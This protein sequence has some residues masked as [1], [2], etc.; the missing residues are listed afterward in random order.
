MCIRDSCDKLHRAAFTLAEVLITLGIIGVVA[1]LTIPSII[2]NYQEKVTITRLEKTYS[3]LSQAFEQAINDNGT[4]DTWCEREDLEGDYS[5]CSD[6]I[7]RKIWPYLKTVKTCKPRLSDCFADKYSYLYGEGYQFQMS[8]GSTM[9]VTPDGVSISFFANNGDMYRNLW[10]QVNKNE[11]NGNPRYLRNCGS[12][13]VDIN[14][15]LPPN[16]VSKDMFR[17]SIYKDGIAAA[18][19]PADTIWI[20][21]FKEVCL[22]KRVVRDDACSGWVLVNKNM[23]YLRCKDLSWTG[24]KSCKEK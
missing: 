21:S 9:Y 10:C 5:T 6:K 23:D 22:G 1:A 24:K 15:A 3:S 17:F 2:R 18:G 7:S 13:L 20:V 12:I 4:I 14:G 19:L 16:V 8:P 11:T